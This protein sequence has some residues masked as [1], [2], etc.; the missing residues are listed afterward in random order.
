[1]R[2]AVRNAKKPGIVA[3]CFW[4]GHGYTQYDEQAVN[5][6]LAKVCPNAPEELKAGATKTL[7]ERV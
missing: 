7:A 4:C 3:A 6:H 2:R 1:L 5:E